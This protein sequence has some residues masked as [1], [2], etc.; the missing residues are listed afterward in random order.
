MIEQD[1]NSHFHRANLSEAAETG[2]RR[3]ERLPYTQVRPYH[4]G[5][6]TCLATEKASVHPAKPLGDQV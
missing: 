6:N 3:Q 4:L 1:L 5:Q 2:E